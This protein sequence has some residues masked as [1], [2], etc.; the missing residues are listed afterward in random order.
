MKM[1][2][3]ADTKIPLQKIAETVQ[4]LHTSSTQLIKIMNRQIDAII[5]SN[6]IEIEELSDTHAAVSKQ[7]KAYETAFITELSKI[8][9]DTEPKA[10]RLLDLK[11]VA[12]AWAMEIEAWH[13]TLSDNTKTLQRKHEQV[14][15]LLEFAMSQN[16]NLMQSMYSLHNEKNAH[17][18]ANGNRTGIMP[19]VAVNQ[20]V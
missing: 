13:K 12:P 15:Q 11:K 9:A 8:F 16:A 17:Y 6:T 3:K 18:G 2:N 20:E 7:F 5:A 4:L 1:Q 14:M 19:G 10:F